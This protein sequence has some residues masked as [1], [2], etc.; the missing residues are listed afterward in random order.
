MLNTEARSYGEARID[1]GKWDCRKNIHLGTLHTHDENINQQQ[2]TE[3]KAIEDGFHSRR[4]CEDPADKMLP[5]LAGCVLGALLTGASTA[6]PV[7]KTEDSV[8]PGAY[9]IEFTDDHASLPAPFAET[10]HG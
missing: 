6:K 7:P 1:P 2:Q 9:M 4:L 8:V 5:L 3:G 10:R